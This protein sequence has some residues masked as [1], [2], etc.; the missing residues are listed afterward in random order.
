MHVSLELTGHILGGALRHILT[1]ASKR[2]E[3][4]AIKEIQNP[5]IRLWFGEEIVE[6]VYL[7]TAFVLLL[8]LL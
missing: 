8:L 7:G 3:D 2:G 1:I 5:G 4:V 6:W